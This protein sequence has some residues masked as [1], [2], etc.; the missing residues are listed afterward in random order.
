MDR[1]PFPPLELATRVGALD[2][3]PNPWPW[4]EEIGAR[5]RRDILA[6]L[7]SD[8]SFDGKA[9]LDFGCGAGRT[10]RHF[11]GEADAA[12]FWGCD[13]D[14][15]SIAWLE[16][17]LSPPL[18]VFVNPDEPPIS[19]PAGK[20]DLIYAVSVFTHLTGSW[21]R[22]LLELHRLL[23]PGGLLLATFMGRSICEAVTGESWVEGGYGMNVLRDG[24][25]WALGGPMVLHDPWWI[26]AHWGRAFEIVS[27][28]DHGFAADGPVSQGAVLMRRRDAVLTP[29]ELEALE[30]G[31]P[32]EASA[33]AHAVKQLLAE[34]RELRRLRDHLQSQLAEASA[35]APREP[36]A[37][38][39][40]KR[41]P[42]ARRRIRRL[43]EVGAGRAFAAA[44]HA[45]ASRAAAAAAAAAAG[46]DRRTAAAGP[47]AAPP[48]S[49]TTGTPG[50]GPGPGP[51]DRD[52]GPRELAVE[53]HHA[54]EILYDRLD[55]AK[56]AEIE[57][58]I[59]EWPELTQYLDSGPDL[60]SRRNLLLSF[61][62]WLA[63]PGLIEETGLSAAQP[64]DEVHAMARG[65]L[66]AAGGL[67][68]A[69]MI[70]SALASAGVELATDVRAGLDFGCSSGRVVRVLAA[71]YPH[72]DWH[73]CDPNAAAIAWATQSLPAIDFFQSADDPPLPLPDA[74]LDLVFAISIWSHFEPGLGL[75]WFEEMHRLIA[76]G[77]HLLATTHGLA[78]VEFY[79]ANHLRTAG[80]SAEIAASLHAH[81]SWYAPE[82]G[83]RGDWGVVNPAWG[84]AFLS[85]EWILTK[86]LPR[87]QVLEFAPGRNQSNQDVYVLRRV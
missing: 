82:F 37:D 32:R 17:N 83:E 64:P 22:W 87:W 43:I 66:S 11:L 12:E 60:P 78:S 58:R 50:P 55:P 46:E 25:D 9:V 10:L 39:K 5:S 2:T 31:E 56:V 15:L 67:Y 49:A 29:A 21:S 7:G 70:T 81:G 52:L 72:V 20:F 74:S 14:E 4:Y 34:T 63:V 19:A 77:G 84:T 8:W 48:P 53:A 33:L 3:V 65:P 36:I 62:I 71:A 40:P 41:T 54:T 27:L 1:A 57:R 75:R 42:P 16:A 30:P 13:I 26:R 35:A 6:A 85:P 44:E 86:L 68:E 61:G 28:T 38:P 45:V 59:R 80:Q 24:E 69:D 51:G 23:A 76:P 73:A 47:A 18:H 79:A